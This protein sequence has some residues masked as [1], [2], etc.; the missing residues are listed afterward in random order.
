VLSEAK[1]Q[2]TVL[3]GVEKCVQSIADV[4]REV[5]TLRATGHRLISPRAANYLGAA[6]VLSLDT[7]G[8]IKDLGTT[9]RKSLI[10]KAEKACGLT[11]TALSSSDIPLPTEFGSE[12][13]ALVDGFGAARRW[14]TV[15]PLSKGNAK[16]PRLKTSP[17]FGLVNQSTAIPEKSPQTEWVTFTARKWGG[18][19]RLPSE[20]DED[21][22]EMLGTF[23]AVYAAREMAKIEDTVY[24]SADGSGTYDNITGLVPALIALDNV[25]QTTG[26]S[27]SEITVTDMRAVR[28][29]VASAA[30]TNGAYYMHRTH[31]QLL[32]GFNTGGNVFF[33]QNTSD[34]SARF[35]GY[36]VFWVDVLPVYG[37]SDTVSVGQ[38]VFGD[39]RFHWLGVVGR[40][41]KFDSS[42][43]AAFSTD[44]VL[45]R[46]LERFDVG[47]MADDALGVLQL[48]D[49]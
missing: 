5:D 41:M 27:P 33:T 43:H 13:A 34:G 25:H 6:M 9:E 11:R 45:I 49:A 14:G 39:L 1:F 32:S 17:A 18:L 12:V 21:A 10:A 3:N 36:P 24:F 26:A 20:I 35:D 8:Q 37:S 30:L 4:R 23:I 48:A 46:A 42:M 22:F 28:S 38:I 44:E 40:V 7:M 19:I 31:E 16:L 2:T 47:L 15:F 29:T